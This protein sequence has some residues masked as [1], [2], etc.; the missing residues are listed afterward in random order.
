LKKKI[1][2]AVRNKPLQ[3]RKDLQDIR[4]K[5]YK[6]IECFKEPFPYFSWIKNDYLKSIPGT[7][8]KIF[9]EHIREFGLNIGIINESTQKQE[10]S[11]INPSKTEMLKYLAYNRR[12]RL[13]NYCK[14]EVFNSSISLSEEILFAEGISR[15]TC[16]LVYATLFSILLV[17]FKAFFN[18]FNQPLFWINL[19]LF[20]VFVW[21]VNPLRFKEAVTIFQSYAII[22]INN[23]GNRRSNENTN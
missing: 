14:L 8:S 21:G 6:I 15:M 11:K 5:Q 4:D 1:K 16:G 22:K 23:N 19:I 7:I 17:L 9:D 18:S 20:S 10:V 13:L 12:L 2:K 3:I